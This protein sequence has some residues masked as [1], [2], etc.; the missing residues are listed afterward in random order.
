MD[1]ESTK[2]TVTT[3]LTVYTNENPDIKGIQLHSWLTC[4][5]CD[6]LPLP[7]TVWSN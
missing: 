3:G 7:A 1:R 6:R 5:K 2:V 4:L